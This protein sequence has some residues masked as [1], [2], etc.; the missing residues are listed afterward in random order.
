MIAFFVLSQ[1][2]QVIT[3]LVWL[4]FFQI[5]CAARHIHFTTDD[6]FEKFVFRFHYLGFASGNLRFFVLTLYGTGFNSRYPLFQVLDFT[7]R[8][9]ILL[10]DVVRKFLDTE[11]IS[12]IGHGNTLHSILHRL[13]DQTS[14]ACLT[15]Q[16]R[17]LGMDM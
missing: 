14:H 8:T 2:N 4:S 6:G 16:E 11:H 13:I 5:H 17:I 10:I 9:A 15:I 1:Y 3:A 12:M 7:F